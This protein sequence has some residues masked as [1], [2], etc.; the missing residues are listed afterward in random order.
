MSFIS[1]MFSSV[2]NAIGLSVMY[3]ITW[4]LAST[5][6]FVIRGGKS[7]ALRF[8]PTAVVLGILTAAAHLLAKCVG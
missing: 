4:F 1:G 5:A 6:V 8:W 7:A 3:S 2:A